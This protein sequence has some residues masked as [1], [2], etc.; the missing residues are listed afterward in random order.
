M[1]RARRL[2][3]AGAQTGRLL[4]T[5]VMLSQRWG[6]Q[7][8]GVPPGK[9][10]Q[11][12]NSTARAVQNMTSRCSPTAF[13]AAMPQFTQLDP[14]PGTKG[15]SQAFSFGGSCRREYCSTR[16]VDAESAAQA[17]VI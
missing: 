1:S 14:A 2:R 3:K 13:I 8:M 4:R 16:T 5:G 6:A 9:L 7:I 10:K 12:R 15:Y 17:W 11:W